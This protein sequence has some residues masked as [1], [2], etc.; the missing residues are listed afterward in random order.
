MD[1]TLKTLKYIENNDKRIHPDIIL[2]SKLGPSS[3]INK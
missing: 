1:L 2:L 3:T